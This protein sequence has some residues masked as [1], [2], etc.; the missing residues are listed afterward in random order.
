MDR[1]REAQEPRAHR[2]NEK[3]IAMIDQY[4]QIELDVLASVFFEEGNFYECKGLQ[5]QH[6]SVELHAETWRELQKGYS[7]EIGLSERNQFLADNFSE[8]IDVRKR[9][10]KILTAEQLAEYSG[11]L[12]RRART[13]DL[14]ATV[15]D[16]VSQHGST[17]QY[18]ELVGKITAAMGDFEVNTG[19]C[20]LDEALKASLDGV[21]MRCRGDQ[22][23]GLTTG[24][25][26]FDNRTGAL[27]GGDLW[28]VAARPGMG[29][30]AL[31]MT[32][33]SNHLQLDENAHVY[34]QSL[35][36]Q[37]T[38][39][40]DRM[41]S[42]CG[43]LDGLRMKKGELY[44]EDWQKLTVGISKLKGKSM[45]IDDEGGLTIEQIE[46][47]I[48]AAHRKKPITLLIVDYLQ[49]VKL[50]GTSDRY[51]TVTEVSQ[52]FKALAKWLDCPAMVLSQLNRGVEARQDKRPV[53]ADLR[54]S[55]AIEQDA[56]IITFIYRDEYYDENSDQK[57]IAEL[58]HSK[59]R[60]GI[61]GTDFVKCE[62]QFSSFSNLDHN[63]IQ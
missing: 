6:F 48:K 58:I 59:M 7:D 21:E 20:T 38:E 43:R 35:E 18:D 28:I 5:P 40:S 45:T 13:K 53:N 19:A 22:P 57:G 1:R 9:A 14:A 37:R 54:E 26:D 61:V 27:R 23:L 15:L 11:V 3:G 39:L 17:S 60:S 36:M 51:L 47:R 4:L 31:A 56:D 55:G 44:D 8:L 30:T 63:H 50:A 25:A 2:G 62:L 29:K 49:L 24:L 16:A 33:A 41:I 34:K 10:E 52:R 46:M 42:Y 12:I 32:V